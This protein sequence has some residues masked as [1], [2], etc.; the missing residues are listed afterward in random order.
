MS[1]CDV[2]LTLI[3]VVRSHRGPSDVV[4]GVVAHSN[5]GA[6]RAISSQ[7]LTP[8]VVQAPTSSQDVPTGVDAGPGP[9][10]R[11]AEVGVGGL[12]DSSEGIAVPRSTPF[13][14]CRTTSPAHPR[15]V[16]LPDFEDAS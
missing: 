3:L 11:S 13:R 16:G 2:L 5:A 15:F 4:F 12:I 1:S 14:G 10:V 8:G 9:H 6:W 7:P